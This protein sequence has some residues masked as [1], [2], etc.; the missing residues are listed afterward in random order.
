MLNGM[1][2]LSKSDLICLFFVLFGI[3]NLI[4][5]ISSRLSTLSFMIASIISL[6]RIYN[7]RRE[8]LKYKEFLCHYQAVLTSADDGWI[9]WNK[10]NQYVG[11]SKK[12][13][14]ELGIKYVPNMSNIFVSDVLFA[15]EKE[16]ANELSLRINELKETGNPFN[17]TVK[18]R[19][20]NAKISVRGFSAMVSNVKTILLWSSNITETLSSVLSL[21]KK[22]YES[23][24]AL[25]ER[26]EILDKLP[27]PIWS[28]NSN[29]KIAYCNKKYADFVDKSRENVLQCNIPLVQGSLFGQGHSLAEKAKKCNCDQSSVQ[30]IA[31]NGAR[32]KLLLS[33][34]R[35]SN[36]SFI[37]FA[38]DITKE[39]DLTISLDRLAK[40]NYAIWDNLS[41]A[42]AI[43]GE[44]TRLI[45]FNSAYQKL[46][47][48]DAVWLHAKPTYS[49]VLDECRNNRQIAECADFQA[50][51]QAEL[52]M[53]KTIASPKQDLMHLP[54]GK[55]L[56]RIAAPY[57]L[58]GIAFIF[59]D[60]TDSLALQRKNNMLLAVQKETID[61][62]HEGVVVYGSDNRVK[63]L[64]NSILKIWGV[65]DKSADEIK[66]THISEMLGYLKNKVDHEENWKE[67][68]ENAISSFTNRIPKMGRL[69]QKDDSIILFSYIPLPDGAHMLS[70]I[71]IT[72]TCMVEKAVMERNT[73][74]EEAHKLRY[75]FISSI[76]TELKE[77]INCLIGFTE[78]LSR[79]YY[80]VLNKKQKEY[81]KYILDSSNQLYQ[82][83]N[84][85][86]EMVVVDVDSTELEL[87]TFVIQDAVNE[88]VSMVE[89][90][91]RGKDMAIETFCENPIIK[92][93]G[94]RKRVK[95]F[96]FNV[97]INT[98]QAGPVGGVIEIRII[99]NGE[100]NV[101]IIVKGRRVE[102]ANACKIKLKN[103]HFLN[104]A[105]GMRIYKIFESK[106]A[107]M[108]LVKSIIEQHGGALSVNTD[109]EGNHCVVCSLPTKC[110]DNPTAHEG[111]NIAH[112]Y[113][114]EKNETL[115]KIKN[116]RHAV[117]NG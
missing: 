78:L 2:A 103:Q 92:I 74:L 45:F 108:L 64:N 23:E 44:D 93:N 86:L 80:G 40:A 62:L 61:H 35:A 13:R 110:D 60:I 58:G 55:T 96:L 24:K 3:I 95:Q 87:S 38:Q 111:E 59:E 114:E 52:A 82:L 37:G 106:G 105:T 107:S 49:E 104:T 48:L 112:E 81:C 50:F 85:L 31:I 101:K 33:E 16:D 75:E 5:P 21:K 90:R 67:F 57:P 102:N 116:Q 34:K 6:R 27:I 72:D 65:N 43:F 115:S 88:V 17:L 79:E 70:F 10:E 12:F 42:I 18:T 94:D 73:A 100:K 41:A 97:L 29:L 113:E 20:S 77:P 99:T 30:L 91:A 53:F 7:M 69:L 47:K 11:S 8:L 66:G 56:H 117:I 63:I 9:A 51:K 4:F 68:S 32:K 83:I 22:L 89:K 109:A 15:L 26:N 36:G 46:M 98:I 25:A 28:R 39:S 71:D 84:N 54:T 1:K 76:S 14:D 19:S